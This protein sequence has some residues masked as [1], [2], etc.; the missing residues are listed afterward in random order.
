MDD[1][2]RQ[3]QYFFYIYRVAIPLGVLYVRNY[4][5]EETRDAA[6]DLVTNIQN[7]FI[8]ML[9]AVS[10]MDNETRKRAMEKVHALELHIA[11]QFSIKHFTL[12]DF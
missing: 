9:Q 12:R 7:M 3:Y 10:W 2:V 11:K 6:I 4:F 5:K 1:E 8:D